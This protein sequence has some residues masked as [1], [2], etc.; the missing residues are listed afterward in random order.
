MGRTR[1]VTNITL[2]GY[3]WPDHGRSLKGENTYETYKRDIDE[4]IA[5]SANLTDEQKTLAEFFDHKFNSLAGSVIY[6]VQTRNLTLEEFVYID[7]ITN[8]AAYD[9]MILVWKEKTRYCLHF[10]VPFI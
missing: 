10:N 9:T 3:Q 4:V 7:L 5:I 1:P 6:Y 8:M 2:E